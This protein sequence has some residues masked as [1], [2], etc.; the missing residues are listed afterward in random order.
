MQM[1]FIETG[2][3]FHVNELAVRYL[4]G[5]TRSPPVSL[6]LGSSIA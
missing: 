1:P 4:V 3:H 5:Q 2:K 6:V